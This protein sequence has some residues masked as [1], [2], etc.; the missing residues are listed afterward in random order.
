MSLILAPDD[1]HAP[2]DEEGLKNGHNG[3][4][5]ELREVIDKSRDGAPATGKA[6]SDLFSTDE[7]FHRVLATAEDEFSRSARL[8]FLS[9]LAAGL[10]IG[11][12]FLT[13]AVLTGLMPEDTTHLFGNLLYPIG[14]VFIV[15]GRYQLFTENTLTPVTLV[16]TRRASLPHLLK[17]WG[18]VFTAN[19]LG[20]ACVAFLFSRT[21]VFGP[22]SAA[23]A[24]AF[25]EHALTLAWG[26]LFFKGVIAGWLV[27]GMV[28]LIHAARDTIGRFVIVYFIMFIVPSTD[29]FHCVIGACEIFYYVFE[30]GTTVGT[31]LGSFLAPVTL[32][33]TVGGV[34]LVALLNYAQ[35]SDDRFWDREMISWREWFLGQDDGKRVA[36]QD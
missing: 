15:L 18:V 23:A 13:R 22:E 33:N 32:G 26:A 30:G 12:T 1:L 3:A 24:Y 28:W 25:G 11:L 35:T 36:T 31:A 7:I 9:G 29:L 6:V 19:V 20:A 4:G 2:L 27:A 10:S 21:S 34:I 5:E 17:V 8:L 16:V 14:F